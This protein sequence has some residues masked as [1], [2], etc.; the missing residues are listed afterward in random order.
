MCINFVTSEPSEIF[1]TLKFFKLRYMA[2]M[3]IRQIIYCNSWKISRAQFFKDFCCKPKILSSNFFVGR[4][5]T[6]N[7]PVSH[8]ANQKKSVHSSSKWVI[9]QNSTTSCYIQITN[10]WYWMQS[11]ANYSVTL[12]GYC[13]VWHSLWQLTHFPTIGYKIFL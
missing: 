2:S 1:L 11:M 6:K 5:A 4:T 9:F 10:C 7:V 3:C 12:K 13:C 8:V